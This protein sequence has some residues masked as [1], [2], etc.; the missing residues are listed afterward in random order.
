MRDGKIH[1]HH[2]DHKTQRYFSQSQDASRSDSA[3]EVEDWRI[4]GYNPIISV[5]S[6]EANRPE[7]FL[8]GHEPA[9]ATSSVDGNN[10]QR[11]LELLCSAHDPAT[12]IQYLAKLRESKL[13]D[14]L[15]TV[16]RSYLEKPRMTVGWKGLVNDPDID[17]CFKI[18]QGLRL[19]R[20]LFAGLKDHG[21]PVASEMLDVISPQFLADLITLGA[22]GAQRAENRLRQELASGQPFQSTDDPWL[23]ES[24]FQLPR[25]RLCDIRERSIT[26]ELCPI[27]ESVMNLTPRNRLGSVSHTRR[28][29]SRDVY[30]TV[31]T[32]RKNRD[33]V[34]NTHTLDGWRTADNQSST[35]LSSGGGLNGRSPRNTKTLEQLGEN[36]FS[37]MLRSWRGICQLIVFVISGCVLSSFPGR[38]NALDWR[39][40]IS[41]AGAIGGSAAVLPLRTIDGIDKWYWISAYI[42]WG[43]S[44][45]AVV[46]LELMEHQ[47]MLRKKLFGCLAFLLA[48][49]MYGSLSQSVSSAMDGITILGPIL[50]TISIYLTSVFFRA[51]VN[52]PALL[53]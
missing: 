43:L 17:S 32:P 26:L 13:D 50:A 52:M 40:V 9:I 28:L 23:F 46:V 45:T 41:G 49:Q 2:F 1:Y 31:V 53:G 15:M 4:R 38:V 34:N 47:P 35:H 48:V 51:R 42:T 11:L 44:F 19:S 7:G 39:Y 12:A 33:F 18:N 24:E 36:S 27:S 6:R 30:N 16:M 3:S 37:P 22:V 14:Q 20:Q 8:E 10:Q 25:P 21:M 5:V 29:F